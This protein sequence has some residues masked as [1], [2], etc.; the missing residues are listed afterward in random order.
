MAS[1]SSSSC[2]NSKSVLFVCLGNICR[3]PIA[4]AVF[5]HLISKRGV[6]S[7][8]TV[9]SCGTIGYHTGKNPEVRARKV[10]KD[11]GLTDY[12]HQA[13]IIK[14]ADFEKFA[15][16]IGMDLDNVLDLKRIQPPG[17]KAKIHRLGEFDKHAL[18]GGEVKEVRDPYYVSSQ[19][20]FKFN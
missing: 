1:S 19:K 4:E 14:K 9:D 20:S 6:A 17:S 5:R 13:R 7:E 18:A 10:L 11:R 2:S 16:I 15:Y 3:S 8:W 12:E